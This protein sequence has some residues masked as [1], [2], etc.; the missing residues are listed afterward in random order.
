MSAVK[1]RLKT[2]LSDDRRAKS[3]RFFEGRIFAM[4]RSRDAIKFATDLTK[5][6]VAVVSGQQAGIV[7]AGRAYS[8]IRR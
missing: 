5:G 1:A 2:S 4:G 3:R 8:F 6:E 7:V